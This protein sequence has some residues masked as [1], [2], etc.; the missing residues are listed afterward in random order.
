MR[1]TA[2]EDKNVSIP[3]KVIVPNGVALACLATACSLS[4]GGNTSVTPV[5]PDEPVRAANPATLRGRVAYSL[6][7][8]IWVMKA[9][10]T[11]RVRLTRPGAGTDFDPSLSPDGGSVVFRT[12][13]GTYLPDRLGVGL[14]GIFV[15]H[16]RPKREQPI[17]PPR[18]GLF[19]AWSPDGRLIAF[20]TLRRADN[21][22]SIHVVTPAGTNLRDLGGRS[23]HGI[24]EGLAWSPDGRKIAYSGHTG[25]GNWAIWV[26]NRDG[27][28]Q[29]Q[30]T[31]PTLV[32]PAGSGGDQVGA[33]SPDG[34]QIV[35]SSGQYRGRDLYVMNA[36][37][38]GVY[39]LTDWP[40]ADGAVAWL[41]SGEIVFAHFTGDEPLPHWY[42]VNP[43]GSNLRSL[44]WFKAGD[45]LDWVQPR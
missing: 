42:L 45:P 36:D 38:T 3:R 8:G 27:S 32:E 21:R 35:Y 44:P 1:P 16:I 23:L 33:W 30:L 6:R 34:R 39:R 24:Q 17:H 28:N 31:H 37:G 7:S 15:V 5:R 11:D 13:R 43:D 14:E 2:P 26:M 22:E 25:D 4:L 41:R 9:D 12:S 19:P 18:G 10:G 40:G 20:S 29:R